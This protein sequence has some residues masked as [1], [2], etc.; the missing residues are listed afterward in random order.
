MK[1]RILSILRF[2]LAGYLAVNQ[3]MTL[4]KRELPKIANPRLVIKKSERNLEIFDGEKLVKSYRIVLGFAPVG[5]KEIEGDGKT[6]LGEF[7]VFTKNDQS[8]FYL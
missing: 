5:D 6:P 4:D 3:F 7:Y 1:K 2:C 8:K